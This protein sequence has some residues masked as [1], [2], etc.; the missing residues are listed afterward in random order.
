[1]I[2]DEPYRIFDRLS[3]YKVWCEKTLP[4]IDD[5]IQSK[6]KAVRQRDREV[7]GRLESFAKYLFEAGQKRIG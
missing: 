3:D 5:I 1:M 6:R 7:L 4:P 2:D